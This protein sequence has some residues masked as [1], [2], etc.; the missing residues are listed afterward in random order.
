MIFA[1][2][3]TTV[4]KPKPTPPVSEKKANQRPDDKVQK[5]ANANPFDKADAKTMAAQCVRLETEAGN[6]EL[7]FFPESA[8]ESVRNFLNLSA[9]GAVNTTTFSRG[10]P[11]FVIQGG[12]LGTSE[13]WSNELAKLASKKL[14]DEP[15]QIKHERG[16]LSM[17]RGDEPN[18][19]TTHFFILLRSASTLDGKFAAFGQVTKGM[20]V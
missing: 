3:E 19:A 5:E 11:G 12:N 2:K 13:K 16:I 20:E 10:V 15:S 7:E 4:E 1:Q 18:S 14:P 8:P 6:I 17:A 9:A